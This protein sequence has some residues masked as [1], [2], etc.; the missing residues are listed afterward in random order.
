MRL[1]LRPRFDLLLWLS[2]SC[3]TAQDRKGDLPQLV[4]FDHRSA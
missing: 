2:W 3:S 1:A 4:S